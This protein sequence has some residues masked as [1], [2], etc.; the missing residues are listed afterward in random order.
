[1]TFEGV[2]LTGRISVPLDGD[3]ILPKATLSGGSP[4]LTIDG[5]NLAATIDS[6]RLFN[7]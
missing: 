6:T 4:F 7:R 5:T 1:M 2:R 3:T